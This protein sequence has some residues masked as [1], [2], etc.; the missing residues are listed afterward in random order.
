MSGIALRQALEPALVKA[1]VA[2]PRR[3]LGDAIAFLSAAVQLRRCTAVGIRPR[4][5]GRVHVYNRGRIVIGDR[6]HVRG[7]PWPSELVSQD[8]AVLEIGDGT[9]INSGV[10][11][12]ACLSI[13]IGKRCQI[14]PRV[15]IMDNDYHVVGDLLARPASEPVVLEDQVW[16]G[17]GAII[18]KG[19]RVGRGAAIAAGS[20]VTHDVPAG[21]VVA[22]VPARP[23]RTSAK[24]DR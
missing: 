13:T 14:G 24:A 1:L 10:S 2:N 15:I 21:T 9:Y 17:A 12:S 8:G 5:A 20:V 19:V 11:I 3:H 18:L 7:T 6:L 16:V 23:I 22:G 4:V